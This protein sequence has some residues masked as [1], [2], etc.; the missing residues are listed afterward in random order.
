MG[1]RERR[2]RREA[3][4]LV[5]SSL[6]AM[7]ALGRPEL[8]RTLV[9][10]RQELDRAIADEVD[11][12]SAADVGWGRSGRPSASVG[13]P[14]VRGRSGDARCP[15]DNRRCRRLGERQVCTTRIDSSTG[16]TRSRGTVVTATSV[17]ALL[18]E[19]LPPVRHQLEHDDVIVGLHQLQVL[20]AQPGD[21]NRVRIGVV[22]L[23]AAAAAERADPGR[24]R[25]GT[26]S[27]E[28]VRPRVARPHVDDDNGP[29]ARARLQLKDLHVLSRR[30]PKVDRANQRSG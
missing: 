19:L 21:G 26:L 8:L 18:D 12:L 10:R 15:R 17:P 29:S 16:T 7:R 24:R 30:T 3:A 20:A 6:T 27:T 14:R 23:A 5:G 22:G 9:A 13:R 25:A 11:R 1:K 2:R 28:A 4:A